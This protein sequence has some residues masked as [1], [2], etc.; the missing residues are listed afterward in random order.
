MFSFANIAP[1]LL[2]RHS[3]PQGSIK[4]LTVVDDS[5]AWLASDYPN[6]AA[7]AYVLTPDDIVELDAAVATAAASGKEVQVCRQLRTAYAA[8]PCSHQQCCLL[9]RLR[10]GDW[11]KSEYPVALACLALPRIPGT[12][13]P[14]CAM[15]GAESVEPLEAHRV[16]HAVSVQQITKA[17]FQLPTLGPRLEA[18]RDEVRFGR[19]WALIR[20]VPVERYTCVLCHL[21]F[22]NRRAP[23]KPDARPEPWHPTS[24]PA[25]QARSC[26]CFALHTVC[27]SQVSDGGFVLEAQR[28]F[29]GVQAAGVSAGVL[30]L[31]P[32]LGQ[33]HEP[34]REG[35]HPGARQGAGFMDVAPTASA[36]GP[37]NAADDSL[38]ITY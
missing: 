27:Q 32:V 3:G 9:P 23:R 15:T 38:S 33:G 11:V 26:G 19:G 18:I 36:S 30:G 10:S 13:L 25:V 14:A 29:G 37:M 35:P 16:R 7:H 1:A 22:V 6:P 12:G 31:R 5:S 8:G 20:G 4:P 24:L 28:L 21:S 2:C 17:E 34:E